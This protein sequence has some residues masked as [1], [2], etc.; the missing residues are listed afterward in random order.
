MTT[1]MLLA[2]LLV[3]VA[4]HSAAQAPGKTPEAELKRLEGQWRVVAYEVDGMQS[5][6]VKVVARFAKGK[7]TLLAPAPERSPEFTLTID[8]SKSPSW[9]D[10]TT[11]TGEVTYRGIYELK[12]DTLRVVSQTKAEGARP[13]VFGAAKGSGLVMYTFKQFKVV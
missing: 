1:R 6:E 9:M 8:P 3:S 7:M 11:Q 2:A 4:Q 10:L 5:D 12:G 13:A